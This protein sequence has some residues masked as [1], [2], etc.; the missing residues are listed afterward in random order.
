VHVEENVAEGKRTR[1]E[2]AEVC[3]P[4]VYRIPHS[5]RNGG[6]D[7]VAVE[8]VLEIVVVGDGGEGG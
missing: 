3:F 6:W 2:V 4:R 8:V 7:E 5:V 1:N